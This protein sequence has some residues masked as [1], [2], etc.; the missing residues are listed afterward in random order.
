MSNLRDKFSGE[1]HE[2]MLTAQGRRFAVVAARFNDFIVEKLIDGAL[3]ALRRTG[4]A[5]GDI[6]IFRCPGAMELP[7]LVR[8]VADS[9][10]FDG[11]ICLGAVIRGATPHFDL[12]VGEATA[13]VARIAADARAAIAYGVLACETIEQAVERAGTKAGNRGFDA[14]MVALEMADLYAQMR[15]SAKVGGDADADR[16]V[17]AS[18]GRRSK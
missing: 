17:P 6:E 2:G 9:D 7:G 3:D 8:R 11:I 5:D 1:I 16:Q 4:A 18:I 14:A 15:A 12:V 13:G 10:R